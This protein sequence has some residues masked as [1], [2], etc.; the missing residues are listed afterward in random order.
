[1]TSLNGLSEYLKSSFLK[2]CSFLGIDIAD[3]QCVSNEGPSLIH[4]DFIRSGNLVLGLQR[5]NHSVGLEL[6]RLRPGPFNVI[7]FQRVT[8]LMDLLVSIGDGFY[9]SRQSKVASCRLLGHKSLG[10]CPFD[11]FFLE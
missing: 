4:R 9:I 6:M 2:E 10:N 1:M 5:I 7:N 8:R 11:V 3:Q